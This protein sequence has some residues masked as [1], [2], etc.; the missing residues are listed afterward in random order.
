MGGESCRRYATVCSRCRAV[1]CSLQQYD[2]EPE[3]V[4]DTVAV[5]VT[6]VAGEQYDPSI[7]G[8]SANVSHRWYPIRS[9]T[10]LEYTGSS[11]ED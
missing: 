8:D 2:P 11:V 7:F 9:G 5:T 10:R 3:S 4:T 6:G 1:D